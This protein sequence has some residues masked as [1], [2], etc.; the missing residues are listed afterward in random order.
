MEYKL[1]SFK[2]C[3]QMSR[4]DKNQVIVRINSVRTRCP[5]DASFTGLFEF[6][7]DQFYGE[8][9]VLF[10]RGSFFVK[11][12]HGT[13]KELMTFL[14]RKLG[15]QID[16]WKQIRFDQTQNFIDYSEWVQKE[17]ATGS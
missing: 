11:A 2:F 16:A 5:S 12:S 14:L 1:S 13:V 17:E 9:K 6:R 10:S 8:I 15:S 3:Q 4:E 7:D